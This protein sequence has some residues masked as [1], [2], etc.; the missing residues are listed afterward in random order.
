MLVGV[1]LAALA[2]LGPRPAAAHVVE[3][4]TSLALDQVE[5]QTQLQEALKSEVGRVL[6]TTIAFKPTMV[7]VTDARQ[8]GERLLVRLLLADEE[9]EQLIRELERDDEG[10]AAPGHIK[11]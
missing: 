3:V 1:L 7:A 9:G 11:L 5:D 6:A 10:S 4:T 8:V 2:V